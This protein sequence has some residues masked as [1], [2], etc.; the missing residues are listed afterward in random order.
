[1]PKGNNII[2]NAHFHKHWERRVKTWFDQPG[3][4]RR[5]HRVRLAKAAAACGARVELHRPIVHC[6]TNRYKS[7]RRIGRGFTLR[8]LKEAGYNKVSAIRAGVAIDYRRK[9]RSDEGL[10]VIGYLD[11]GSQPILFAI[12]FRRTWRVSSSSWRSTAPVGLRRR[13]IE[14][15]S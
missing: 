15:R 7:K 12:C 13:R 6:P 10:Q 3:R 4:K 14:R 1:M 8:E 11:S 9:N 5:R 2:P